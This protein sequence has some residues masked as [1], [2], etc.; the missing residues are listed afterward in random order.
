MR[1]GVAGVGRMGS[2]HAATLRGHREVS[3]LVVA[4]ADP[5]RAEAVAKDL[6]AHTAADIDALFATK[7]DAVVIAAATPENLALVRRC[8]AVGVAAFCEKPVT[9]DS[10][11]CQQLVDDVASTGGRL[12]VGFQR[13]FDAEFLQL[14]RDLAS[15]ECGR[16]YTVRMVSCD[17]EPPH[18]G[19]IPVSGGIFKD[20]QIHDFDL[21]RWL[22]GQE[23][24]EVFAMGANR[25]DPVF[26]DNDDFDAATTM[27]RFDDGTLATLIAGR[28]NPSGYDVR[29]EIASS[30]GTRSAGLG[31]QHRSY[32]GFIERFKDAYVAEMHAFLDF[33]D[34]RAANP[35]PP[36]AA[37]KALRLAEAAR[38]STRTGQSVRL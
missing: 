26:A 25:E 30:L 5:D 37:L 15:G 10:T 8:L 16:C 3:D 4:D 33:A 9:L 29:L 20:L 34:D 17:A 38:L 1:V 2:F 11:L 7:P 12:Q 18:P 28:Y 24:V 27:L 23:A 19:Y 32:S 14:Q 21:V 31:P 22:T 35:C 6:A 36:D 13:R